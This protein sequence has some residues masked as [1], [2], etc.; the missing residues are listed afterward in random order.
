MREEFVKRVLSGESTMSALCREY[1]IS[2]PTGYKWVERQQAGKPLEDQSRRPKTI[3]RVAPETERL[4]LDYR[5]AHPAIGALK[6]HRILEN[7]GHCDLPSVKTVNNILKRNGMI[8]REASQ[9]ATPMQRFEKETPNEMWQADYKGHFEMADGRRCHPLNIIDDH[10]R[11][12]LCCEPMYTESYQEIK[13]VMIRLFESYGLPRVFLCDNGNPWGTSQS[14]GF[15][16][17]EVWLMELGILT[18]HGRP[19]HPQTQGK[20]ESFNRSMTKELLKHTMILDREDARKKFDQYRKFYNEERPHHALNLDTP[21]SDFERRFKT[22]AENIVIATYE[23]ESEAYQALSE[24]KHETNN[25]NYAIS[26]AVIVKK[27]NGQLNIRDGFDTGREADDTWSGGLIGSL[28]GILGGPLGILLGGSVGMMIGGAVD[29]NDMANHISLLER[30][31]D[32]IAEGET[33]MLLLAQEE[34]ETALTAKL[35]RFRVSITRM[36]AA[37]IA[38][39]IEHANEVEKQLAKD[40]RSK[41]RAEKTES[42]KATV[43]KKRDE[44]KAWFAGRGEK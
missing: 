7:K 26:Q 38:A 44:L 8:T 30:A 1:G 21:A 37:E 27:E 17:F 10:S 3:H 6:I 41:L 13:P 25:A 23:V 15:T 42:F 2:R 4:I 19:L 39:E 29:A 16:S 9:A 34:Y 33:A 14:T 35:N 28:I 12:N 24:I 40:A 11:F 20:D 36:D 31:G 18:I 43:E 22:M 5:E 32:C